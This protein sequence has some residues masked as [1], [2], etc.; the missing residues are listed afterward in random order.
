MTVIARQANGGNTRLI[1]DEQYAG[2][3]ELI[4]KLVDQIVRSRNSVIQ[5][6]RNFLVRRSSSTPPSTEYAI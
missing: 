4:R 2:V 1:D 5:P 3:D 6:I